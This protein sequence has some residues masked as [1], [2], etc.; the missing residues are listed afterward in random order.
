MCRIQG[1]ARTRHGSS[2]ERMVAASCQSTWLLG[3]VL[4]VLCALGT[5]WPAQAG[6]WVPG[7]VHLHSTFS[8]GGLAPAELA[9]LAEADRLKFMVVADRYDQIGRGEMAR[10][11]CRPVNWAAIGLGPR[12]SHAL[13]TGD[14]SS[15][16]A[17]RSTCCAT[18]L[19]AERRICA[20]G[21]EVD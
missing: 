14:C 1:E 20:R 12:P 11:P 15:P 8:D 5:R 7:L 10:V 3:L 13:G 9:A 17:P 16:C 18:V 21:A 19:S 2:P 4:V 6:Q